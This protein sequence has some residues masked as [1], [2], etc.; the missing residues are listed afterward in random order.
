MAKIDA[1]SV[2]I[3]FSPPIAD[4]QAALMEIDRDLSNM[5]TPLTA[6]IKQV[7]IPSI[8]ANFEAGGRP[9]WEP[10]STETL[11]RR[12][13]EG[14]GEKLLQVTGMMRTVATQFSRWDVGTEEAIISNWPANQFVKVA[15]HNSGGDHAG[16]SHNV[17]IPARPFLMIQDEDADKIVDIFMAWM[18]LRTRGD[19]TRG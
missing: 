12:A 19:W 2:T 1:G 6:S 8:D 9:T 7:I 11:G 3:E 10:L 5:R 13:R 14:T 17:H 15:V 4:I 16:W 18:E